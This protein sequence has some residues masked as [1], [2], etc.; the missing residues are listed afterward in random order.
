[1]R[2]VEYVNADNVVVEFQDEYKYRK[3]TIYQNF[4]S[5][6]IKN[7]YDKSVHGVGC[8]GEGEFLTKEPNGYHP[9]REYTCWIHMIERCYLEKNKD[10]HRSYYGKC[11]VCDE[12]LN[13]QNFAKWH[14]EHYYDVNE[15]LHLDKDILVAGNLIYAPDKCILVPQRINELFTCKVNGDGLPVGIKKVASG[16]Y[17]AQY[18][19]KHLGT[20]DTLEQAFE[21]YAQRKEE[22]IREVADEYINI[23]PKYIY[24]ALVKYKVE[25]KNDKNIAA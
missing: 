2:I 9:T 10:L 13:F 15:R 11:I 8:I 20:F 19:S 3:R 14:R 25:M 4:K 24:D 1:M 18:N 5:G 22:V 12:W 7:P 6:Q 16:R 21:K 23:I 17:S